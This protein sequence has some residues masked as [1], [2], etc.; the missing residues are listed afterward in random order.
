VSRSRPLLDW[1]LARALS[2]AAAL[3]RAVPAPLARAFL[4]TAACTLATAA[5]PWSPLRT[6]AQS[7]RVPVRP[8]RW[9]WALGGN[10]AALCGVAEPVAATGFPA[11]PGPAV[12]LAAHSGPWEAGA[13]ELARRGHQPLIIAAPWPRLP[14][15][16]RVVRELR[17]RLGVTALP[18][19]RAAAEAA[20]RHLRGGGWVV[21]LIDSLN[22]TRPGRRALPFVDGAI[23]APDGLVSWAARQGASVLVA[24]AAGQSFTLRSVLLGGD[25]R[26][27][28]HAE[29]QAAS[30]EVVRV[31]AQRARARPW[32]WAWVRA[33]AVLTV[34]VVVNGCSLG[35]PLPPLPTDPAAWRADVESLSWEGELGDGGL[36]F[37]ARAARVRQVDASWVGAFEDV[38]LQWEDAQRAVE[39][40]GASAVGSFPQGP[41]TLREVRYAVDGVSGETPQLAWLGGGEL[42]CG[43]CPLE[44]LADRL[45]TQP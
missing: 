19:G 30:D 5:W 21:V 10:V 20:T 3:S 17:G 41:L 36:T 14:R 18:R 23:G 16:E 2:G 12:V 33:L 26:R 37:S 42:A 40:Q 39:V 29:V 6:R 45:G 25:A 31:L 35:D 22:P 8:W 32:E 38:T 28:P 1:T 7:A 11:S 13:A 15:T 43:G 9:G 4:R 44:T 24:Q 34:A 27:P